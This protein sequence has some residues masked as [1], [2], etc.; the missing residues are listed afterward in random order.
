MRILILGATGM[1]GNALYRVLSADSTHQVSGTVRDAA[2]A[3]L[4]GENA[5]ARLIAGV[6]V[7]RVDALT[8]CFSTVRPELVVNCIGVVKQLA[9][10]HDPLQVV[11]INTLL[12]HRLARLCQESG[13]RL[14]HIS[15]DCV[16]SGL[17]GDYHEDDAP[18]AIDLYGR[19]KLMGEV[20]GPH[21]VT[22]RTSIIGHELR[23]S[24]GL[25]GWFLSQTGP[26]RGYRRA[27]FS[28]LPT[29]EL[30]TVIRDQVLPRVELHGL[31][32]VAADPIN[33]YELLKLFAAAYGR[34]NDIVPADEP[35]IN[36]S[37]NASRFAQA[38]GYKAPPWPELV[39]RMRDFS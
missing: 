32:H 30:A 18:D 14:V 36:R 24:H 34:N 10:A 25:L 26:V 39:R 12:P 13:A 35:V 1:L 3:R 11:P 20:D 29:V 6:D 23:V 28:G 22:L 2:S 27:I 8:G 38:T 9:A 5:S 19:S 37:L 7:E 16:Y 31:Y 17:K 21:A 33:K 15:T 4:L